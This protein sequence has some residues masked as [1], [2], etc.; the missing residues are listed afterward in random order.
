MVCN[1][2]C[3][4]LNF[5]WNYIFFRGIA[6]RLPLCLFMGQP[7]SKCVQGFWRPSGN[8]FTGVK[9][10]SFPTGKFVTGRKRAL[11]TPLQYPSQVIG[12]FCK[13]H[14]FVKELLILY[15]LFV[16]M[17]KL[18]SGAIGRGY[19]TTSRDLC[20]R[21]PHKQRKGQLLA[22]PLKKPNT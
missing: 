7:C 19:W 15:A 5:T 3:C 22:L 1:T 13:Q 10:Y 21:L 9:G 12:N 6:K 16:L 14:T 8:F 4:F 11:A 18:P 17:Y 2:I 20:K